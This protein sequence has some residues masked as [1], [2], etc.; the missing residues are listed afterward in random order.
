MMA[1]AHY[2]LNFSVKILAGLL[3]VLLAASGCAGRSLFKKAAVEEINLDF[4]E[5][6]AKYKQALELDTGPSAGGCT[7]TR[8]LELDVSGGFGQ[9]A[10]IGAVTEPGD[11]LIVYNFT[12]EHTT[13]GSYGDA[14]K[15]YAAQAPKTRGGLIIDRAG[16][17][18]T[19]G[20][21]IIDRD[22]SKP[23]KPKT[24]GGLIID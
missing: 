15:R 17:P 22:G 2:R 1:N 6:M 3:T 8:G 16:K 4:E 14:A 5:A 13:L 21:L 19:R 23:E 9:G 11:G 18:Q 24:R 7:R 10:S 20:G 12:F